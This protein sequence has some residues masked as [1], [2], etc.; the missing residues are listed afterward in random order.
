MNLS[1]AVGKLFS[2]KWHSS[3]VMHVLMSAWMQSKRDTRSAFVFASSTWNWEWRTFLSV[4]NKTQVVVHSAQW[5]A[6]ESLAQKRQV[7][8]IK[9]FRIIKKK[10]K[11]KT[12]RN[13]Q[14]CWEIA[15]NSEK[16]PKKKQQGTKSSKLSGR[17]AILWCRGFWDIAHYHCKKVARVNFR[18][19]GNR[20][21]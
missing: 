19:H 8:H 21:D 1:L 9:K 13:S 4:T 14:I 7:R 12:P 15:K 5:S 17:E 11:R 3:S 10:K 20:F 6:N 18:L 16:C 2:L